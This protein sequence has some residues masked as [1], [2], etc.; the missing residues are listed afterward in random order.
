VWVEA[1]TFL[2]VVM[3]LTGRYAR[4]S[5][6]YAQGL[7]I[8]MSIG[9]KWFAAL[10]RTCLTDQLGI[11]QGLLTPE[12]THERLQSV[13]ADWRAIGDPRF[14]AITLNSL[15]WNA[16][17]LGRY[18]EALAALEESAA[19]SSSIGDRYALAFAYRGLGIVAQAQA[20]HQ[21]AVD[22]FHQSLASLTEL[23]ARHDVA[24]V[25][26]E[27]SRSVFALGN[28]AEAGRGWREALRLAV[29]TRGAFIALEALVGLARLQAKR[30]DREQALAWL[31]VALNH[32]SSLQETKTRAAALR[33]E[34]EAQMT[35]QQVGSAQARSEAKTLETLLE[36]LPRE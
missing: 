6:L 8:A 4:A 15:S 10:C 18:A 27:M 2:G 31:L 9:D 1:I 11:V 19:L 35:S 29:E 28:D 17:A 23:G 24:R 5:E 33:L 14:T 12:D 13:V 32:P 22:L 21:Q 20:N 7:E 16:L 34:L 30:G 3:E 26:A 36:D 25:L